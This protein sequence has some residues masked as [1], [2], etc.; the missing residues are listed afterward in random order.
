[1]QNA[2]EGTE[3]RKDA[4]HLRPGADEQRENPEHTMEPAG[5]DEDVV[6]LLSDTELGNLE[7]VHVNHAASA[8][9]Q[10][11]IQP[12]PSTQRHTMADAL[13]K[14]VPEHI[15]DARHA[16]R[17]ASPQRSY[18]THY[19]RS[20]SPAREEHY[21]PHRPLDRAI[22]ADVLDI[23][24]SLPHPWFV[25]RDKNNRIYF[26]NERTRETTWEH[27]TRNYHAYTDPKRPSPSMSHQRSYHR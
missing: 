16:Y 25:A 4:T 18:S 17:Q 1:M 27:P 19:R 11:S 2:P 9:A 26:Y 22:D 3:D 21:R 10:S 7:D 24:R 20:R 23:E 13:V 15:S 12:V 8:A 5:A 14:R 6:S